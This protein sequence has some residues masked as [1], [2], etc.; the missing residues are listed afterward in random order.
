[1]EGAAV[2]SSVVRSSSSELLFDPRVDRPEELIE[3]VKDVTVMPAR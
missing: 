1:V 3:I 2:L